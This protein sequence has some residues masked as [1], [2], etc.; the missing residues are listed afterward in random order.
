MTSTRFAFSFFLAER[1]L[2]FLTKPFAL[3]WAKLESLEA[4]TPFPQSLSFAKRTSGFQAMRVFT[5]DNVIQIVD[6]REKGVCSSFCGLKL[7]T[8]WDAPNR[9][10]GV[11]LF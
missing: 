5:K 2:S 3:N 10:K 4:L 7:K 1:V 9:Y 8:L 11:S 6:L